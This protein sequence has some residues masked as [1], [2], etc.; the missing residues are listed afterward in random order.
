M[1]VP[2]TSQQPID[3]FSLG[4]SDLKFSATLDTSTDTTLTIPGVDTRY[5]ALIKMDGVVNDAVTWVALNATAAIPA[6]ATFAATNSEMLTGS[7]VLC[8]DVVA[9]NVLHFFTSA[10]G[11]NVSVVLYAA[12]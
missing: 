9:G 4:F 8:R 6:G 12:I 7:T 1:P 10:S 3:D 2:Y 5:K 11:V